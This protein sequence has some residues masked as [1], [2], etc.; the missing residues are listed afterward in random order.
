MKGGYTNKT[1]MKTILIVALV[2]GMMLAA[3]A[4][5]MVLAEDSSN[6]SSDAIASYNDTS[7]ITEGLVIAPAPSSDDSLTDEAAL[8]D[9]ATTS[10]GEIGWN[11]FKLWFT[12]N[13]EKKAEL[14]LKLANLRLIQAR[15]A[16]RNN[17]SEAM[18]KALEAHDRILARLNETMNKLESGSDMK[19]LNA[20][21]L[22]L[23]G[24]ERAIQVHELRIGRLN[25]LLDNANLSSAKIAKIQA[26]IDHA[27]NVT[28]HLRNVEENKMNKIKTKLMAVGN[29]TEDQADQI[30]Q[31][32]L[33]NVRDKVEQKLENR[34]QKQNKSEK[35]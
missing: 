27:Q 15:I 13:Q 28:T 31:H 26:R 7:N 2:V 29:L 16:A 30:V 5:P 11:H 3:F 1:N 12:L 17:D 21:A 18:E 8:D 14:E 34:S 20:S 10:S 32:R 22:K 4:L 9:N 33:E 24:L 35:D 6:D 25:D 23:I 19:G